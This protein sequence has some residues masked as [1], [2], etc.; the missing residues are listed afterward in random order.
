MEFAKEIR[1]RYSDLELECWRPEC[2]LHTEYIWQDKQ[3]LIKHR[4]FPSIYFRY[5]WELSLSMLR[6]VQGAAKSPK[7]WFIIHGSYNLHAYILSRLLSSTPTI[8]QSHGG[9]PAFSRMGLHRNLLTKPL[10]FPIALTERF[11]LP[12]YPHMFVVSKQEEMKL[13]Q[14]YPEV[15][16]S[17]SPMSIDFNLFTPGDKD[18][19]R[20]Y[21]G[22]DSKIQILLYAGRLASEKGIKYLIDAAARLRTPYSKINLYILGS[23]P[24]EQPLRQQAE[25]LGIG[26]YVHFP[27]YINRQMLV[28]WYQSADVVCLP[29]SFEGF[30]LSIAE[31]LACGTP[32]VA[33]NVGG[34]IDI[35]RSFEC[36][37][38]VPPRNPQALASAVHRILNGE[39]N[40]VP[41][42]ETARK[43]FSWAHK[44][45]DTFNILDALAAKQGYE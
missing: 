11:S 42:I 33:S 27:G 34:I 40:T 44:V 38:T 7:N 10:F 31:A 28:Y 1:K 29:S 12:R 3:N 18:Q 2:D 9:L 25:S 43:K 19:S 21:L 37:E 14:A 35:V 41:N 13:K 16:V 32:V 15:S 8:L 39:V 45:M 23:G 20:E 30:G 24:E 22:L 17:F 26:E 5:G 6:A 36:G 4:I